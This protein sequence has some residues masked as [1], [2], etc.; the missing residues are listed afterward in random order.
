MR[1]APPAIQRYGLAVISVAIALLITLVLQ[2]Y[3]FRH[4][5]LAPFLLAIA[6]TAWYAGV[7]A[8]ALSIV[9]SSLSFLYFFAPPIHSFAFTVAD[10]PAIVILVFFGVLIIGFSTVRRRIEGQ[11]LQARDELLTDIDDRKKAE[12]KLRRSET[13]LSGAQTLGKTGSWVWHPMTD[14][15][16]YWSEELLRIFDVD[17]Q[18]RTSLEADRFIARIHPEDRAKVRASLDKIE[19]TCEYRLLLP[20]GKIKYVLSKRRKVLDQTGEPVEVIGTIADVTE[21]K[22]AE[23]ARLELEEQWRAAFDSNPTM[24]F[25]VDAAGEIVSVNAFG[26]EQLGYTVSELVGQPVLGVFYEPDRDAVQKHAK[27]CFEQP[28]RMGRW[29]ARKI[30]KDGTTLWVRETAN[31]VVLKKRPVLLVACENITEQKRAEDALQRSEKELRDAI[32]SIPAMVFIASAGPSNAFVSRGWREY[33]GLSSEGTAGAGWQ[34]VVHPEDRERHMEKWRACSATGEPYEDEARFRRAADGEYRWFLV[35]A[36]PLLDEHG[37]ILKWYGILTDI[38]DR[39]RA[40]EALRKSE[41]RWRS[42][43]ENSAIGVVLADMNGRFL[44]TNHAYQTMVGYT[45]EELRAL[46]FLD[47]THE[48][49][50]EANGVLI[51]ELV[52]GKRRQFQ[53]EKKYRRKD[54]GLIWVSNNVSLVPGT[55]RLPRFFMVLSEDITVRKHAEQ[56]LQRSEAYL[57]ES[58]RLTKTGSWAFSLATEKAIYW[59]EELFRM[60]ELDP[61]QGPPPAETF[62]QKVHPE[63]R[64]SMMQV[65]R[66]AALEKTEYE[67][68]HRLVLPDGAVKYMHAIAQPVF[69][70]SGEIIEYVG[71]EVDETERKRAEEALRRSESYLAEAQRL[72]KTGS[73][74]WDPRSDR[75]VYCSEELYRMFDI[76]LAERMPSVETFRQRVHPEDL[77]R[78]RAEGPRLRSINK[79]DSIEYKLLLSDGTIRYVLSM[80]RPVF[81]GAGELVEVIGTV[82]DVTERKRAE[83][84]L[85]R[86]ESYLA[87]AQKLSKTGSWAWD[88]RC[89][90]MLYCSEEVYRIFGIDPQESVPSIQVLLQRVHPED[91]DRVRAESFRGGRDKTEQTLEYRLLLPDGR[92]KYLLSK[93]HPVFDGTG[94]LAEIIGTIVDVTERKRSEELLR[95][96]EGRFRTSVD[97]LTDALFIHNDQDD[98]GRVIDA[99]QQACDSLGYTR[100]ELI[101]MTAFD[102]DPSVDASFNVSIR[103]RLARG[104]IFS[105]ESVHRRKDGTEFPVEVRV[106]PFRHGDH[107]FGLALARNITD[108]KRA[109]AELERLRQL[110]AD[111]AQINRVSMMGELAA[112]LAHEV[113][114]PIAAAAT[115]AKTSLRWLQRE[116][117]DIGEAR[118]AVSRIV[119]DVLRA[120]DIIDRNRSLYRRDTPKREMLNLNE[121]IREMIVLLRDAAS[122][123][124]VSIRAELDGALPTVT[125]DRVQM[126]QVLMNLMLNG[127]EAMK[128]TGG[129]LT[130]RSKKTEDPQ[131]LLSVS[132][133][134]VGLP[135]ENAERIFDAFFTTKEQGT[136]MGLS[137]SRRIIESHGG[138]LWAT[139]NQG[140]GATFHF[141]VPTEVKAVETPLERT[142]S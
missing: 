77:E 48:D 5:V 120:A 86:S 93:R 142:G 35:R 78:V 17:P 138:R 26:A 112:S 38:E 98:K 92:I 141:I 12:E 115:N 132:D 91:Q 119:K 31:A 6:I 29:E 111:L 127:I 50:H 71:T 37:K 49:H 62:L 73:W 72:S 75:M 45:D 87:E 60:F 101:G 33:T 96:S 7:G 10:V 99:N 74:A 3:E 4:V 68:R 104:E 21:H 61:L 28:G 117:P 34:S 30:H 64:D 19:Q 90:K 126:Q 52:E 79:E 135:V 125:G 131:I 89:D 103:E 54:G 97:H 76:D 9:L 109:E 55:E 134:G 36:V 46:S 107:R 15:I 113:K 53:I 121:L 136:G 137:I 122:R 67:H 140:R 100:E 82:I 1:K 39:R 95:E 40:E 108:R 51:N 110:E 41:E 42:V 27:D 70:R 129:E 88:P 118:E 124:S 18:G 83:E 24:Y 116:P 43:F 69:D 59:S 65:L 84:A 80:Q 106:R 58:Q 56:A 105:F 128:D 94:D 44:T 85:R 133:L 114:Q 2:H 8:A 81:D 14:K 47:V 57:A 25:I 130:I 20:D 11:L 123:H 32:E 102:Y 63:D 13:Y 16:L 66:K 23:Q 22:Q 139:A